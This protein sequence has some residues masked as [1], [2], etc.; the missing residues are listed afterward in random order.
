MQNIDRIV[1][2]I[3]KYLR[4][5]INSDESK[6]LNYWVAQ[7]N[8]N[9]QVFDELT[10]ENSL[11]RELTPL[12]EADFDRIWNKIATQTKVVTMEPKQKLQWKYFAAAC[13]LIFILVGGYFWYNSNTKKDITKTTTTN[14]NNNNDVQPG[15][16]KAVLTLADGTKITLDN[17]ANGAIAQQGNTVVMKEDGLLAYNVDQAKSQ[18]EILYN[19][20]TTAKGEEYKS[21]VLADGTKVWL[22]SVSSI[23]FPTSFITNERIVEI[24]GELY[25]EVAKNLSKPFKVRVNGMEVEVL[26]THFNV[27]AYSDEAVIKTTLLKGSVKVV[28][29]KSLAIITPGQQ[30]QVSKNE[31]VKVE[32]NV[33]VE[34]VTAW[35]NGRFQFAGAGIEEVMRQISRWYDVEVVYEGKPKE[36]HFRGGIS[37]NVEAS[38]VFKML[39]TT[40]AIKFRIEG[41]K[42]IVIP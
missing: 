41:K 33:D 7:N 21:L 8:F 20:L 38:K 34:E 32:S 29:G 19:T 6:E 42:V 18:K 23:R 35:K 15:T 26:G 12:S 5:E 14:N 11:T 24:T 3:Q 27:N 22:N 1:S 25:F 37:R 17:T 30:A 4:E 9:R 36:Q 13:V 31:N 39:E 2:L 40:E 16:E 28:N 10:K